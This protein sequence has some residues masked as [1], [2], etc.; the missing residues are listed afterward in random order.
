MRR[1]IPSRAAHR[2]IVTVFLCLALAPNAHAQ[3]S[4]II[5]TADF[6]AERALLRSIDA[7]SATYQAGSEPARAVPWEQLLSFERIDKP[8]APSAMFQVMLVGGDKAAGQ[9]KSIVGENLV[10]SNP[11]VGDLTL[12]LKQV[13]SIERAASASS[14]DA[15]V[16]PRGAPQTEDVVTLSNGDVV[17]GIIA[18]VSQSSVAVQQPGGAS[19]DVPL[20]SV[21]RIT[22]AST[23]TANPPAQRGFRVGLAD[24][25]AVTATAVSLPADQQML[26]L[27]LS[28]GA[29]R[30]VPMA[31]IVSIEHVNGP[32]IWLSSLAPIESV[33]KSLLDLAWPPQMDR[34]VDGSPIRFGERTYARGIGVHSYSSL[35]YAVDPK[36]KAFRTRYAIAGDWPYADVTVRIKLDGQ[37]VHEKTGVRSGVLSAPVVI[38]LSGQKALTLEVDY[39]QGYDVQDRLNWIEPTFLRVRPQAPATAATNP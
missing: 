21:F 8:V 38:D 13:I 1:W 29:A 19:T 25:S 9:P 12:P 32:V 3:H 34:A 5:T 35:T 14:R 39:G 23:A 37:A 17:R 27:S 24:G 11:T 15:Q 36:W 33:Q 26:E 2:L 10:W 7:E 4:W 31:S 28:D 30:K 22:F 16:P 6:R 18:G 20:D